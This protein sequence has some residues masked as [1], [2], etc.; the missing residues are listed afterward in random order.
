MASLDKASELKLAE[1]D[2]YITV[3]GRHFSALFSRDTGRLVSLIYKGIQV[4]KDGQGPQLNL[5]RARIDND[6]WLR[7]SVRQAG[8]DDVTYS[9]KDMA[10]TRDMPGIIRVSVTQEAQLSAGAQLEFQSMYLVFADGVIQVSNT[11]RSQGLAQL[12]RLG[13]TLALPQSLDILTWLG[14]GPHESYVDRQRS[15]DVGLYTGKV[16]DQLENYVRP[17][18]NGNKTDVRWA[19]LTNAQGQGLMLVTDGSFSISAHHHTVRD[20][21]QAR[22]PTDLIPRAAVHVCLDAGH[23]GLGG[24]SCG[25]PPMAQYILRAQDVMQFSYSLR[26]CLGRDR[27]ARARMLYPDL[28]APQLRRSKG[29]RVTITSSLDGPVFLRINKGEWTPYTG[30]FDYARAGVIEAQVRLAGGLS[31]DTG[32]LR[33]RKIVPLRDLDRSLWKIIHTSSVE[34]G[35]GLAKHALDNNPTTF[36]HTNW[37]STQ[38][39]HPHDIQIDL[40][41]TVTLIGFTQL[42]RQ[43]QSNGRIR[44]YRFYAGKDANNWGDPVAQGRFA[45]TN[46]LQTVRLDA[47]VQARFIKLVALDEWSNEYYTTIAELDVMAAK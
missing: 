43:G 5:Y 46:Q 41:E 6:N 27:M 31:S 11:I 19:T 28:K 16:A 22:H 47:P 14:R 25:P 26:P 4:L 21:D 39:K 34:P 15:A 40:G 36:W 35:E 17:Q 10:V 45:N 32:A 23:S 18:D 44:R 24:N 42:P 33:L 1:R 7:N 37:S 9:L 13:V 29:G 20:F 12:P 30:P 3:T 2:Q 8:L 38:E